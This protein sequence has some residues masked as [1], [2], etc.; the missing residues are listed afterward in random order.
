MKFVSL[1]AAALLLALSSCSTS[2]STEEY[3]QRG[4]DY[5]DKKEWK[6]A[7][8]EYK[9]SI[10][11]APK[12]AQARFFLGKAYLQTFSSDAAIKEFKKAIEFGFDDNEVLQYLGKAY[13][14][15]N[16]NQ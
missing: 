5:M 14:Q 16:K 4:T 7:I 3:L 2:L 1:S 15:R 11:Q 13:S 12:N 9:N 8:I 6:S 10:K